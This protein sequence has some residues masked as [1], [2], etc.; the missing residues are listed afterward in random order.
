MIERQVNMITPTGWLKL[1]CLV[2]FFCFSFSR[3][4][5]ALN[6]DQEISQYI[7]NVWQTEHGLPQNHVRAIAQTRNGYI[8][9]ATEEGLARFDGVRFKVFDK[10]N[11]EAIQS[12]SIKALFEDSKGN[13]W[14]G[15]DKGLVRWRD[16][17]FLA[18]TTRDGLLSDQIESI[19]ESRTGDLWVGTIGGL[20]RMSE[21][22]IT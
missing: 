21:G 2:L 20:H 18:Y 4:I 12:N 9:I 11:T 6:P 14:I 3:M 17:Q 22:R 13:L 1:S 7:H 8:W 5:Y 19:Y 15:T 10:Q 16:E